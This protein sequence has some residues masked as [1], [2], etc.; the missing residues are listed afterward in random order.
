MRHNGDYARHM[1]IR[2]RKIQDQ[3]VSTFT[4]EGDVHDFT[5]WVANLTK[6]FIQYDINNTLLQQ[7]MAISTLT[8]EA[9]GWWVAHKGLRPRLSL[10]WA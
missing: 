4:G 3:T 8:G 9:S 7:S 6:H 5:G 1:H 2:S 10:S